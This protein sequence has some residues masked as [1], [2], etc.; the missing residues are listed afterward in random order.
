MHRTVILS[1]RQADGRAAGRRQVAAADWG[2]LYQFLPTGPYQVTVVL[3]CNRVDAAV[4]AACCT[5]SI[6]AVSRQHLLPTVALHLSL[7]YCRNAWPVAISKCSLT[8]SLLISAN[9]VPWEP[10][11]E[12]TI[13]YVAGRY[14]RVRPPR[15]LAT[16]H[17]C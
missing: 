11:W 3:V 8:R 1:R 4:K 15:G 14:R 17:Q 7:V 6:L 9:F 12:R 5:Q 16:Q 10:G 13:R 2:P